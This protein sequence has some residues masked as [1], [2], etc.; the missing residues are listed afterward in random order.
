MLQFLCFG[1]SKNGRPLCIQGRKKKLKLGWLWLSG[2]LFHKKRAPSSKFIY[3]GYTT[4]LSL[5]L[6]NR[7]CL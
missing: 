7:E 1:C 6:L 4:Q 2:A 5:K 3:G